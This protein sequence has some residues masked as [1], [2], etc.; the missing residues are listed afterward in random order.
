MIKKIT[1]QL[2]FN[3]QKRKNKKTKITSPKTIDYE[4]AK[5]IE[6]FY[7][8]VKDIIK[9]DKFCKMKSYKH[10]FHGSS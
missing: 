8:F 3:I 6:S 1:K 5:V 10:H 9:T 4:S 2:E 7:N